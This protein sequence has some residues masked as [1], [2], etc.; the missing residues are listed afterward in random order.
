MR[1]FLH[2]NM[3]V[4][5]YCFGG[6][7]SI[8]Y[9]LIPLFTLPMLS[10][11]MHS[12]SILFYRYV[13]AVIGLAVLMKIKGT[14]FGVSWRE[15]I[16]LLIMGCLFS[17]SSLTLFESYSYISAG[18]ASTILFLY[19]V[20]VT[21]IMAVFFREK[22]S[23]YTIL[24]VALAFG[25]IMLLYK[26]ENG[27]TLNMTGIL[28]VFIS[29]LTYALYIVGVNKSRISEMDGLKLTFYALLM[30]TLFF[31]IKLLLGG[32]LQPVA[33]SVLWINAFALGLLPTL[34]SCV[35][36]VYAVHYIGST[37]TAVMGAL[38]PVTAV[39]ISI[40]VFGEILTVR[41]SIGV[42]MIVFAV[43]MM[44]LGNKIFKPFVFISTKL[45]PSHILKRK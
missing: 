34:V 3:L 24:S 21:V 14:S 18:I 12:D 42:I 2:L 15:F 1:S 41:M 11:G 35:A 36:M 28:L 22:I 43:T 8:T 29:S 25:G 44:I 9:G 6:L 27:E 16:A 19:P 30:G 13:I 17:V 33:R 10:A 5:G 39:V 4:K 38:E 37:P 31:G 20:F 23:I 26:G 45:I 32:G 7:S 40:V